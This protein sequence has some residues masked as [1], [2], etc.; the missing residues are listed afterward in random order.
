MGKMELITGAKLQKADV[1]AIKEAYEN[2]VLS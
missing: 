2:P 1:E